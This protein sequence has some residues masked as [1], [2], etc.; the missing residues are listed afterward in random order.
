MARGGKRENFRVRVRVWL[1]LGRGHGR[2]AVWWRVAVRSALNADIDGG[3]VRIEGG[4]GC[5]G[6][7]EKGFRGERKR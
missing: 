7:E 4:G 6:R 5:C 2:M 3:R 1:S